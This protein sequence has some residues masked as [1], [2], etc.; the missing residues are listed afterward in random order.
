MGCPGCGCSVNILPPNDF[1]VVDVKTGKKEQIRFG[2]YHVD[3]Y[4]KAKAKAHVEGG[5]V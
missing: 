1:V 2:V 4:E 3:C 5:G